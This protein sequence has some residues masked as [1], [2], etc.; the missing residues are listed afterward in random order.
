MRG[1]GPPSPLL[2]PP[3]PRCWPCHSLTHPLAVSSSVLLT[4]KRPEV[5]G[6]NLENMENKGKRCH[7]PY[8]HCPETLSTYPCISYDFFKFKDAVPLACPCPS[9]PGFLL[10]ILRFQLKILFL[11]EAL[12]LHPQPPPPHYTHPHFSMNFLL[13]RQL[14]GSVQESLSMSIGTGDMSFLG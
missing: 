3:P 10:H 4:L 11:Q 8:S 1:Q 6:W 12:P 2:L 9:I 14:E 13:L 5:C 7:D